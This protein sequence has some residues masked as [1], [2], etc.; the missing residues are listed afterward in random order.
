MEMLSYASSNMRATATLIFCS[1]SANILTVLTGAPF[2]VVLRVDGTLPPLCRVPV[3]MNDALLNT[4]ASA[5]GAVVLLFLGA[6]ENDRRT[7][8]A[9]AR[10]Q[11]LEDRATLEEQA[12]ELVVAVLAMK[13]AG[14][15]HDHQWGSWRARGTVILR[16]LFQGGAAYTLSPRDG[17]SARSSALM[18]ANQAVAAVLSQWDR[19]SSAATAELAAPLGRLGAAVAPLMRRQEPGLADAVQEVLAAVTENYADE[20]RIARAL[21]AFHEALS[22]ALAAPAPPRRWWSLRRRNSGS[23]PQSS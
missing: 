1:F 7:R 14:N 17:S 16:A 10:K 13:V 8:R 9:E 22:P 23:E 19:G 18:A 2:R 3:D 15:I 4:V 5:A 6:W 11:V 21:Q 20:D 12:N